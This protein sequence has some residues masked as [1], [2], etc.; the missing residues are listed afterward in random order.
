MFG[1][2]K[3]LDTCMV[4]NTRVSFGE[5]RRLFIQPIRKDSTNEKRHKNYNEKVKDVVFGNSA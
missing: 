5:C 2:Q 1:K 4:K 3:L